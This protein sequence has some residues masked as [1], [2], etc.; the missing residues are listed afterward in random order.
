MVKEKQARQRKRP[1]PPTHP[2]RRQQ[3]PTGTRGGQP[4]V[5]YDGGARRRHTLAAATAL[6]HCGSWDTVRISPVTATRAQQARAQRQQCAREMGQIQPPGRNTGYM[7]MGYELGYMRMS[8]HV[9]AYL[10][11]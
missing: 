8:I 10:N 3:T 1:M 2:R 4:D 9:Y 11:L 6:K 5:N 7:E